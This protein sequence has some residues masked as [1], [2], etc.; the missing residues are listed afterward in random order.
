MRPSPPPDLDLAH[1]TST[2]VTRGASAA[3]SLAR[4]LT[5]TFSLSA[6]SISIAAWIVVFSPQILENFRRSSAD[7]LSLQFVIIWLLG[8]VF[9]ILGAVFQGVL[10]TMLIL[11]IY[12]TIADIVLLGQC[13]YYKGFT[14]RDEVVPPPPKPPRLVVTGEPNERTG[15]LDGPLTQ[16]QQRERRGSAES[17]THFNP[18]V[19]IVSA[20]PLTPPPPSTTLQVVFR[21]AVAILMVCVAGVAGWWLSQGSRAAAPTEPPEDSLPQFDLMGQIFGWLCATLYLGSRLP[22]MILNW[23]RKSVEGVSMLFFLF[24]CLGNLTYVLSIFAYEPTCAHPGHCRP[25][26]AGRIYG[27]YILVNLSWLAGSFGTLLLDMGIFVQFFL[28]G[29]DESLVDEE[30]YAD[31]HGSTSDEDRWDQRPVLERMASGHN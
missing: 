29:T 2:T 25:G 12:Y 22:Q 14:W 7:G 31:D 11:A 20:E 5:R 4:A 3:D 24:A 6:R 28:Y 9:N 10:P 1:A 16:I 21:N 19:P 30:A 17:W 13:F 15:L 26:E 27:R 23:R 8:D 18:V